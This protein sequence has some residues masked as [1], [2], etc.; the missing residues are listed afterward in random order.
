MQDYFINRL[1]TKTSCIEADF[2]FLDT[3]IL[4]KEQF[5]NAPSLNI[6]KN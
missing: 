2:T 3:C 5:N 4:L 6:E 1:I